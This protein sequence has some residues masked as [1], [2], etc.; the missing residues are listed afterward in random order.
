M[1][2]LYLVIT[3]FLT[4][5]LA[6]AQG[7][8]VTGIVINGSPNTIV[9]ITW[10]D[11]LSG[12]SGTLTVVP[13][14][15]GTFQAFVP[16][17]SNVPVNLFVEACITNCNGAIVCDQGQIIPGTILTLE[18][19]A[20]ASMVDADNDGYTADIDCNDMNPWMNPG[21]VE[22]CGNGVDNNCNGIIDE[23]CD[24][25]DIDGDSY[26][27]TIDCNDNDPMIYPGATE[28]CS[29]FIDNNCNGQIDENCDPFFTDADNDGF[30]S[31]EDCDDSNPWAYPGAVEECGNGIDNDCNGLVDDG[32]GGGEFDSDGDGF[33]AGI[34]CDDANQWVYPDAIEEC[35]NG[36]DNNCNGLIDE[37]CNVTNPNIIYLNDTI[38]NAGPFE[39]YILNNSL[40]PSGTVAYIWDFGN[41]LTANIPLPS[42]VFDQIGTYTI[43]LTMITPDGCSSTSCITFTVNP[44]GSSTGGGVM[45]GFTLNVVGA[46]PSLVENQSALESAVSIYPNPMGEVTNIQWNTLQATSGEIRVCDMT[47]RIIELFQVNAASGMNQHTLNTRAWSDGIYFIQWS[48]RDGSQW[49]RQVVK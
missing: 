15:T 33:V 11:S 20:C 4:S 44:D 32:C 31:L 41:G 21:E 9:Q 45:Q 8:P 29:D 34:D 18:L 7:Y 35:G 2:N 23:G 27:D 17:T 6:H 38:S 24:G 26:V 1:K 10:S 12:Q 3:F 13:D 30:N 5:A 25:V 49:S 36:I 28:L 14:G 22:E 43:C 19:N 46:I 37:C 39:V 16:A 47:G 48:G 40:D 42:V